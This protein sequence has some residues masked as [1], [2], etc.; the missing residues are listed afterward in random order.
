MIRIYFIFILF[1]CMTNSHANELSIK[2]EVWV[3]NWFAFYSGDSLI[4][5]DSVSIRTERSFNS[6][7]F[8]FNASYP[9]VFNVVLKDFKENDTGLEY[10]GSRKQQLGDGGFIAQFTDTKSGNVIAVTDSDWR[11]LVVHQAPLDKSCKNETNPVAGKSPCEFIS[12]KE[13]N[14]WKSIDFDDSKWTRA[15]EFSESAIRPKDGYD[16]IHWDSAAKLIW[17]ADLETDNTLLCRLVIDG[18][19]KVETSTVKKLHEELHSHFG[20]FSNVSTSEDA[21]YFNVSSNG[22]PEHNMMVGISSWQQQVPLPQDYTGNNSWRIPLKPVLADKPMLTKNHFHKGAVA[23]AVNGVPLFNALNNRGEYA[24]DVGELDQWGGHSGKADDYHYHLAPEHLESVVGKGKPIAYALDGFPLYGK[25]SS[26]LD[27]YLGKFNEDGSYQYH[28]VDYQPY[29]IAGLRG[30]VKTD[31]P[32]NAPE[33]Q[34][35]PQPRSQPVRS[36]DYGP[37]NG[38][39]ITGFRKNGMNEYS[40]EY[41]LG[42]QKQQVNYSWDE[43]GEYTFV[44]IDG[45]KNKTVSTFHKNINSKK[46]VSKNVSSELYSHCLKN[47]KDGKTSKNCCDCL[48]ADSQTRKACRD[49]TVDYNF[50][51]NKNTKIFSIPSLLGR[52]GDYSACTSTGNERECKKCC[53]DSNNYACGDF[54]Y[55]RTACADLL[56]SMTETSKSPSLDKA[57]LNPPR[58]NSPQRKYCGDGI[59]DN[60]ESKSQCPSDC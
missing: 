40:L 16:K 9:L 1:V 10:I 56:P 21:S 24:A 4:I 60:T 41:R 22:M 14:N 28:A 57:R 7:T 30:Q 18:K 25:T 34:I 37:L 23:I 27:E 39:E 53:D 47:A 31:S 48:T 35:I 54:Q 5:E 59:C 38:A 50:R 12:R 43:H 8:T 20:A 3:D 46:S 6:E 52:D 11:C 29:F 19:K 13:P 2:G 32:S 17:S 42:N 26:K 49:A 45:K 58:D 33:D 15:T 44:L 51:Q 55:C 36:G